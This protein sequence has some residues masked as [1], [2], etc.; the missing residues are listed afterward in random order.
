MVPHTMR[1]N[2]VLSALG[3]RLLIEAPTGCMASNSL[4]WLNPANGA[5]QW[6]FRVPGSAIGIEAALPF[7]SGENGNL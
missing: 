7:Y 2:H 4:L 3:S 1:D 6:L 5:E